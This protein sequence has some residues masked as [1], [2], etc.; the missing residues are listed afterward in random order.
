[1]TDINGSEKPAAPIRIGISAC[2][3]GERVRYDGGHRLDTYIRDTLGGYFGFIPLCPEV[4]IG[5]GVPRPTLRLVGDPAAP[6]AVGVVDPTTDVTDAL[7]TYGRQMHRELPALA[8]YLWKARSPS[9]GMERVKVYPAAGAPPRAGRGL[10]AATLMQARPLL[11]M[12]EEGRLG[13]PR[14]RENFIERVFAYHRWQQLVAGGYTAADLVAF[15]SRHKLV[16]M[17]HGIEQYRALGRL[18][19][20]AGTTPLEALA[21]DYATIFMA[22]LRRPATRLRHTNVLHHLLGYLKRQLD[23]ADKAELLETIERYRQGKLPLVA[24]ITLLQRHFRRHPHAYVAEQY[25][26]QPYPPELELR[27]H[28]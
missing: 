22:A 13:D 8:G 19:A 7:I 25:Y 21:N 24:P 15:H 11:P 3:L 1:M 20:A 5:L 28:I 16:L 10:F 27:N 17:S 14:L 9:C 26:L 23:G 12:E 6:R 2:L 4:A 18:V